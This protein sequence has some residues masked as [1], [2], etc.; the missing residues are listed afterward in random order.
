MITNAASKR[1]AHR[2]PPPYPGPP[3]IPEA[4]AASSSSD[5]YFSPPPTPAGDTDQLGIGR[6]TGRY[7]GPRYRWLCAA[8]E[9]DSE[10]ERKRH[11]RILRIH[12][13]RN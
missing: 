5:E 13:G 12:R 1:D 8:H 4:A 3:V 2:K 7:Q 6:P 9:M 10:N 11:A